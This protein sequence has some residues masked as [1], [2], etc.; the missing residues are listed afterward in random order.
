[1]R[2]RPR[3]KICCISSLEEARVAVRCAADVLGL[4]T[5]MPSG[6]GVITDE[7]AAR[8]AAE[9][10]PG[11]AT[12]LLTSRT[13]PDAV[14]QQARR[15]GTS[16]VQLVDAVPAE[17]Y[18]ALREALPNVRIVQVIHVRGDGAV[19]DAL[20]V[21]GAVDAILLDSGN[22]EATVEELG[23]T[24]RVHDWQVSARVVAEAP[25][26]VYLAG[27]LRPDNVALAVQRV[28]PFGLDVCSGVRVD[29]QLSEARVSA[30]VAAARSWRAHP[31]D[32]AQRPLP[33]LTRTARL[34]LR[35]ATAADDEAFVA[36]MESNA[37]VCA[38]LGDV[39]P[40]DTARAMLGAPDL[41][42]GG[43]SAARAAVMA[44]ERQDGRVIGLLETYSGHPSPADHYVGSLF[45][46]RD[47]QRSGFGREI[48]EAVCGAATAAGYD[49]VYAGVGLA[50]V[51]ALRFW[52]RAGFTRA[53]RVSDG[54]GV[55]VIELCRD[56]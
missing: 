40:A 8:I 9:C 50:N 44:I 47:A 16:A 43:G 20:A 27:G 17:T 30:L 46:R 22:P 14:V 34:R 35:A 45:L 13:T 51:A 28:R 25:V 7:L 12:F 19:D 24:G 21:A 49:A 10:P 5:A 55:D 2:Y 52:L 54:P 42:P 4:V 37:D 18:A 3:V 23:G 39:T 15:C 48:A 31:S 26:P 33:E 38:V 29:G 1:M 53:T 6:P 32:D 36:I 41:P 56:L 11:V